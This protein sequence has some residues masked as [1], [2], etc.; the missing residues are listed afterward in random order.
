MKEK[1]TK[2][3]L[4]KLEDSFQK[5]KANKVAMNAVTANGINAVAINPGARSK[6]RFGFSIE[7]EAG[8]VC[9]QKKSGRCWMFASYNLMRLEIMKKLNLEN[10]ELSQTYPL[11]Y[12]KLEKANY[13]LE[14]ML[15]LLDEPVDSR[16][17]SFL[18]Q[19]PMEDG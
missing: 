2:K 17:V 11:F 16:V 19:N 10:M 9:N 7:I 5:D 4:Q 1:I 13:F 15:E 14:N 18:L 8:K 12:D 3:D 6:N